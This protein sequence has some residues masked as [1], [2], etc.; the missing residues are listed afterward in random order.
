MGDGDAYFQDSVAGSGRS[1]WT[2]QEE[3]MVTSEAVS[4][5]WAA[6][7]AELATLGGRIGTLLSVFAPAS[8]PRL[9]SAPSSELHR[10][11]SRGAPSGR[12]GERGREAGWP[13][14]VKHL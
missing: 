6:A 13:P 11:S 5:G 1:C 2:H 8:C 9:S 3:E 4:G 12:E 14:A 7:G 10:L